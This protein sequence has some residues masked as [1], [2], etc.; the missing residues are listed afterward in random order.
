M[1]P[2]RTAIMNNRFSAIVE[3]GSTVLH[4]TAH[5]TFVKLVQDYQCALATVE[6]D[7]FAYPSGTGVTVF[8]GLPLQATL[9]L[10][11]IP[12]LKPGDCIITNDPF[13]TEGLLTHMMDVTMIYPVFRGETLIAF[14]WAFVHASDIGGGVPGSISPAFT[15]SF[16]EGL[17]MRPVKLYKAGQLNEEIKNVFL[18]NSRIPDEMWGDFQAMLSAMKRMEK[19]LNQLCDRYG[20]DSVKTGMNE[21][22]DFAEAKARAII[23]D[24]PDGEYSFSDYLEGLEEGQYTHIMTTMRVNGDEIELDFAGTDP[25]VP[26]AYNFIIGDR[27]HPYVAQALVY[28]LLSRDPEAPKNAGLLRPISVKAKRGTVIN[29]NYPAAM[30][31]RVASGTRVYDTVIG[32]LDKALPEGLVAAGAGMAGIIVVTARDKRT[33]KNRVSVINPICGGGGGRFGVDGVDGVDG[34]FGSLKSVP[35]EVIEVETVM[36]IKAYRMLT[37]TQS[38]GKWRGGS[39]LVMELENTGIEAT[40]TVRG[41]NR[42]H[43]RPWGVRGGEEGRLATVTTNPGTDREKQI[44]KINVLKMDRGDVV[45]IVTPAG[46]GF[47]DPLDRDS[48][49]VANDVRGGLLSAAKAEADYGVILSSDGSVSA[50]ETEERRGE[51]RELRGDLL[52]F[53]FGPERDDYDRI[54]PMAVRARLAEDV[55]AQPSAMRQHLISEVRTK[56][57]GRGEPVNDASLSQAIDIELH[58]LK[59]A[60]G[61]H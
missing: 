9:A 16:Q 32:C 12:S 27:T 22:I 34:R 58:A 53:N 15:E 28:F 56:L 37:D 4:R 44:G 17:R 40:M 20:E 2:I 47:G 13:S 29:A 43:F 21:V 38:A 52:D 6:G 11:D 55:L 19:R 10:I 24:I 51:M 8:I 45:S 1:D 54:W 35:T 26:A 31:S 50:V 60:M 39:A 59:T 33:G 25:Q 41:M 48:E 7:I 14:G 5:T 30:G 18:D 3:E 61:L 42:F 49:T 46:G 23:Q 36:H 57:T